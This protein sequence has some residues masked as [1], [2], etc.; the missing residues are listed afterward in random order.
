MLRLF[1]RSV[2]VDYLTCTIYNCF[3]RNTTRTVLKTAHRGFYVD[4]GPAVGEADKIWTISMNTE[5]KRTPLVLIHGMGAGVGFWV[6]NLDALARHR[7]VYAIDILG[8]GRSSRPLFSGDPH[9]AERQLVKS[10]EEWRREMNIP[11]M[12]LLGH[13]LG[14]FLSTSYT[15][16]HPDRVKHL[17]LA[18]PWGF[19]E[20][21]T[22][23][24]APLW[25]RAIA[26]ALTP[27]NPLWLMRAAGPYGQWVVEKTRPD[28]IRK[29][30][31]HLDFGP[32]EP[33]VFAQYIHQCNA[34]TPS[35]ESAFHTMMV[36]LGWAK[37]PM[38]MRMDQLRADKPL[39]LLYGSRSWIDQN[40]WNLLK[41]SRTS[42]HVQAING[43]GHH[44]FMDKPDVFN[45]YV[46]AACFESDGMEAAVAAAA[47]AADQFGAG[48]VGREWRWFGVRVDGT[49]RRY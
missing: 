40:N 47:A 44:I 19:Q 36:G 45:E 37:H 42:V 46:N 7:P 23:T 29:F 5:S 38:L 33:N 22:E 39:T 15:M 30:G 9:E 1:Y 18:D 24:K 32:D 49:G 27:M 16:Q 35:G 25:V 17:I 10:I 13:S 26:R 43:A 12:I 3:H 4:I 2:G 31:E 11:Q 14:G 28:L 6:L 20:K 8:F 41:Q 48:E 21:P 34:Q